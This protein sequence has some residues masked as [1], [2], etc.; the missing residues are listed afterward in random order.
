MCKNF[1]RLPSEILRLADD[2]VAL[3]FDMA[4]MVAVEQHCQEIENARAE[5]L[6]SAG[7]ASMMGGF[8]GTPS[9]PNSTSNSD[10]DYW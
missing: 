4:A 6:A 10:V 3:D 5:L 8:T 9:Q 7:A 2:A 1:G